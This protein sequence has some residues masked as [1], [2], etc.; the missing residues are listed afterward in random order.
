M[1]TFSFGSKESII[2]Q[3]NEVDDEQTQ[4]IH[5]E[6]K[7][8]VVVVGKRKKKGDGWPIKQNIFSLYM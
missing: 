3:C 5:I 1:Y 8:Q 2:Y 4:P 7:K 6:E